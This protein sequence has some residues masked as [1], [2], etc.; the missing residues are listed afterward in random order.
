LTDLRRRPTLLLR[1]TGLSGDDPAGDPVAAILTYHHVAPLPASEHRN[2]FVP[3][4]SF[5]AQLAYLSDQ[6]Y[7]AVTLDD[8]REQLLGRR[9]LPRRS[10]AITFDDGGA[11]NYHNALPLL[12][13]YGF[14]ATVFLVA[15]KTGL[16]R[17][18]PDWPEAAR[19]YLNEDEIAEMGRCGIAFG[20]H[21]LTHIRLQKAEPEQC[22]HE[23]TESKRRIEEM[24]GDR[25]GWLS[26]PFG[27]FSRRV[28]KSARQAGYV[29]AVSTIRDNRP[30]RQ[31]LYCLPRVMVMCDTT[32]RRFAYYLS[33]WY[34]W[35]HW[36]KNRRRWGKH[37]RETES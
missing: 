1:E 30:T 32:L 5:A 36:F 29:G 11:D 9:P 37:D 7:R 28:I 13:R 26:Y 25:A 4:D 8:V 35:L 17:D 14:R 15:G 18:L 31:R 34:H 21:T 16:A 20:S 6:G 22:D 23:L 27:S 3:L 2:L 24:T 19:R 33:P 10:V 12:C